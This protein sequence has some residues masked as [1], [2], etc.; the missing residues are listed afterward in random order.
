[1]LLQI[2][3]KVNVPTPSPHPGGLGEFKDPVGS[4]PCYFSSIRGQCHLQTVL[5]IEVSVQYGD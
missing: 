3:S 1:M 5:F 4:R 2:G